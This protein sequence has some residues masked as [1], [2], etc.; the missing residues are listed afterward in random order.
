VGDKW[1]E[2]LDQKN[3]INYI[4]QVYRN[5]GIMQISPVDS[6]NSFAARFFADHRPL[7]I[8]TFLRPSCK[9]VVQQL[10]LKG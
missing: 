3:I 4:K 7:T 8:A 10:F 2:A 9:K 1:E 5:Y 6:G